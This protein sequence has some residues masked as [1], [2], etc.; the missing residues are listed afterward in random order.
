MKR[1]L[2]LFLVLIIITVIGYFAGNYIL[3]RISHNYVAELK[4]KLEARGLDF[5][6]LLYKDVTIRSLRSL[7]IND[8]NLNFTLDKE[9]YG[10]KSYHS[11]FQAKSIVINLISIQEAEITFS[12]NDF[13]LHIEPDESTERQTFG[14]FEKAH[15]SSSIPISLRTPERSAKDILLQVESLFQQNKAFGLSLSGTAKIFIGEE[16]VKL[17]LKTIDKRDSAYLQFD[18]ADILQ[19]AKTFDLELAEKEAEV[20]SNHPSLVPDMMRITGD[21]R[22][23]SRAYRSRDKSFPEDAFRHVYWSYHLTREFGYTIAKQI[24]DAHETAPGNT[25]NERAMDY[26][27]N[28]IARA[29]A[30]TKLSEAQIVNLV[31]TSNDIIRQPAEV[32]N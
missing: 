18:Q 6:E 7:S 12:L 19:A 8:V 20:I 24:T 32:V 27:N 3:T 17:A 22:Q 16:R 31:L 14:E 10:R 29:L 26:H 30:N 21:A 5:E 13:S 4:I 28:E 25:A 2:K 11:S 9:I 15:F 23:K 1:F